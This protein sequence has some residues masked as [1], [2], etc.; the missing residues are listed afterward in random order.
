V[1]DLMLSAGAAV[2]MANGVPRRHEAMVSLA[3]LR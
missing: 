2:R 1:L 3:V